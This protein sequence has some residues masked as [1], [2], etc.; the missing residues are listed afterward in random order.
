MRIAIL[1]DTHGRQRTV[2]T[3]LNL[4]ASR[5]I[6]CILHCGDIDDVGTVRL[7]AGWTT[8]FVFGNCD[9]D[10]AGLREAI[11]AIGGTLHDRFGN[12]ELEG[13]KIAWLHG[14]DKRLL[15]DLE[16]S[17]CY[18]FL[19]YGHSHEAEEHRTGPTRV[20]N[21]GALHRARIKSFAILDLAT[22]NVESVPVELGKLN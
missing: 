13:R 7:F 14:D 4:L 20:I 9:A 6:D 15:Q 21:P 18:D 22:G 10:E 1:S 3:V 11:T 12:L 16:N 5:E 8:H 17:A 19:F 2:A